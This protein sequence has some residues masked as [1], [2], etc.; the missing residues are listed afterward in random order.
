MRTANIHRL[1]P[2]LSGLQFSTSMFARTGWER[3]AA[4]GADDGK[5]AHARAFDRLT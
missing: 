2:M 4:P 3:N 5:Q 1:K